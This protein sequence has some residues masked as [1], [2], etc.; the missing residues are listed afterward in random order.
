MKR[1][2][3][4]TGTIVKIG[5]TYFGRIKKNN[6]VKVV[7]LSKNLRESEGLWRDWLDSNVVQFRKDS[8]RHPIAEAWP[9]M[10]ENM[11][12]QGR[13]DKVILSFLGFYSRVRDW[14]LAHGKTYIEDIEK[15]DI[16]NIIEEK[17]KEM[18]SRT[19]REY[20]Y[21][22][23]LMLNSVCPDKN[24]PTK[25]I[26]IRGTKALAREPFTDEELKKILDKAESRG[27]AWKVLIEVGLYTGL[28]LVD[29]VYLNANE[30]K[31][32]VI[33]TMPRKTRHHEICVRI[34]IN[35]VL[36]AELATITPDKDGYYFSELIG[37][38]KRKTMAIRLIFIFKVIG[39][40]KK[41]IEGR[42]RAT[43]TKGFHALRATFLTRL[44][45]KGVSL[46]IMESLAGHINPLQT[47]HY[48]HPDEEVKRAAISTLAF[49]NDGNTAFGVADIQRT[50]ELCK[51]QMSEAIGKSVGKRVEVDVP[52]R[53]RE[54]GSSEWLE[55]S[56]IHFQEREIAPGVI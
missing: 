14:F 3:K 54:V 16:I 9:L 28:R 1:R 34:P 40:I 24:D 4:G 6:T 44:A 26:K 11:K 7:R 41:K 45:E 25:G 43:P 39:D 23:R 12:I 48:A 52:V 38:Y 47:L 20:I 29:C 36:K 15:I 18:S 8:V 17:C 13:S 53:W 33:Q 50:L 30:I 22:V 35:P 5:D 42:I 46:P 56:D 21:T 2:Q 32:D 27:H 31:D 10:Y 37:H 49:D 55:T 19:K 51:Q